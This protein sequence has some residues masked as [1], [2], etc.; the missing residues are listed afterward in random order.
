M[1]V[2]GQRRHAVAQDVAVG[3]R[4][5]GNIRGIASCGQPTYCE[6]A[7]YVRDPGRCVPPDGN[8]RS[9]TAPDYGLSWPVVHNTPAGRTTNLEKNFC[10]VTTRRRNLLSL[11]RLRRSLGS[12]AAHALRCGVLSFNLGVPAAA[13]LSARRLPAAD[14]A[15]A[16]RILTVALVPTPRLV[17]TPAA[18]AQAQPRAGLP[19]SGTTA[20]FWFTVVGAHGS[21][22]SQG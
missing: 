7:T 17:R 12:L 14:F 13:V 3:T 2:G 21:C 15:Q 8:R 20:V 4:H 16:S 18:F 5:A 19:L 9:S 11:R 10:C 1:A 6:I 22:F